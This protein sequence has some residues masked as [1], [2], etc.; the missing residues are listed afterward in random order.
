MR[1]WIGW[2]YYKVREAIHYQ[3]EPLLFL[4]LKF[5]VQSVSLAMNV[6]WKLDSKLFV[7]KYCIER[8]LK[9]GDYVCALLLGGK[10]DFILWR[11]DLRRG[12]C[13]VL[14]C[15]WEAYYQGLSWY[16][17]VYNGCY[18]RSFYDSLPTLFLC[19]KYR[20]W[21]ICSCSCCR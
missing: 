17:H 5:L 10:Q 18:P 7:F 19:R 11:I 4:V 13:W 2:T 3:K 8:D 14:H 21:G 1:P 12:L 9:Y 15:K 16:K 20:D 6:V